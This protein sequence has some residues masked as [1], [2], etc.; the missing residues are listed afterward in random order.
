MKKD[1]DEFSK[2]LDKLVLESRG[3][4]RKY[5][6]NQLSKIK[7]KTIGKPDAVA[8]IEAVLLQINDDKCFNCGGLGEVIKTGIATTRGPCPVCEGS[9]SFFKENK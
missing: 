2:D 9:G 8:I 5:I 7:E 6:I 1:L 4:A 3:Q